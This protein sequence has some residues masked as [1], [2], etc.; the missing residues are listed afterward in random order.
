M[1]LVGQTRFYDEGKLQGARSFSLA[2]RKG[3]TLGEACSGLCAV[4][5]PS[6]STV[7]SSSDV[8]LYSKS[9]VVKSLL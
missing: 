2:N 9:S 5:G 3:V 4:G 7:V 8:Q 6:S 1:E